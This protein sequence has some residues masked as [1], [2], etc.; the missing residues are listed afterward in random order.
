FPRRC[1][2][3]WAVLWCLP[4]ECSSE[5]LKLGKGAGVDETSFI[6]LPAA[7]SHPSSFLCAASAAGWCGGRQEDRQ[8]GCRIGLPCWSRLRERDTPPLRPT[9]VWRRRAPAERPI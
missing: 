5:A 2:S 8:T 1:R 4:R 3:S 7:P 9:Q 6:L